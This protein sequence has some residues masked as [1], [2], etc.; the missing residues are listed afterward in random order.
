MSDIFNDYQ[1]HSAIGPGRETARRRIIRSLPATAA[2]M[3]RFAK[4]L[5]DG[6]LL[7]HK[8]TRALWKFIDTRPA[9]EPVFDDDVL[10]EDKL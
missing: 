1:W 8:R 10:T 6:P 7:V 2:N 9:I 4:V 5:G 3:A